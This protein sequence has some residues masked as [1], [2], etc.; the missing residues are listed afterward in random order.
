MTPAIET[1]PLHKIANPTRIAFF[2]ASNNMAKMG[3]VQLDS[4][5]QMGFKGTLYPIHPKER[6]V[7]GLKAYTSVDALTEVPDLAFIVLPTALVVDTLAACGRKGIGHAVVISAG[8]KEM[9]PAGAKL[10]EDL[11]ETARKYGIR[12]LG[13]NCLGV[14]NPH[15]CFNSTFLLHE[16]EPG[17]IGMASQSGSIVTQM[18]NYLAQLHLGYSTAFSVG[19]EADLDLL[20]CLEY[21]SLCPHTKVIALYI[22]GIRRGREFVR[23][24]RRIVP[25]K[26]IVALYIGGSDTGKRA[27][28]SHTGALSG[29]DPLYNGMFRQAG[30]IRASSLTELFDICWALGTLP[31]MQG[32]QVVIQTNS[33]GPGGMAADACGR[34]G[35]TLP[36]LS[37]ATIAKL[38]PLLPQ[39]ASVSN[40]VDITFARNHAD[41][42]FN[43]PQTLLADPQCHGLMIYFIAF[44]DIFKRFLVRMGQDP[45]AAEQMVA[46]GVQ[47][48]A[49]GLVE[50]MHQSGKPIIGFSFRSTD[51]PLVAALIRRGIPIYPDPSRAVRVLQALVQY[52]DMCRKIAAAAPI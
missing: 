39:T 34:S 29:P 40:P 2:G 33:G 52:Q 19:N 16:G 21:L 18:F 47:Q 41:Y 38:T 37:A 45:E 4:I 36:E 26:P 15:I 20:D 31:P 46:E 12:F 42:F 11:T 6:Q 51:E 25:H 44:A 14:T 1:S 30:I 22:E 3:T 49:D 32:R 7:L 10:E 13:P 35:L 28:Q 50:L 9:G 8:F 43:I 24:A 23:A 27:G 5:L 17:F 48:Q